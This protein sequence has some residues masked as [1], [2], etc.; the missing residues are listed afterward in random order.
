MRKILLS[1]FFLL[2]FFGFAQAQR[3]PLEVSF[4]VGGYFPEDGRYNQFFDHN[5]ASFSGQAVYG[6]KILDFKVGFEGLK[7]RTNGTTNSSDN[8]FFPPE[9][10][11]YDSVVITDRSSKINSYVRATTFRFGGAFHPFRTAAFS[12]FLGVGGSISSSKGHATNDL[13]TDS[14]I[15][16]ADTAKQTRLTSDSN[17]SSVAPFSESVFGTYVEVGIQTRLPRNFFFVVEAI[18]DFRSKDKAEVIGPAKGGGTLLGMRLGYR[19]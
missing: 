8:A 13:F 18:R 9:G 1:G 14:A 5:P 11:F 16:Y 19:F 3:I 7:K 4:G 2:A 17:T 6:W 10:P 15:I 12:P